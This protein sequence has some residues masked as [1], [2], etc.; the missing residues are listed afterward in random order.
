MRYGHSTTGRTII[1]TAELAHWML[2]AGR[3]LMGGFYVVAGVHHFFL[4]EPLAQLIS[5]RKIPAPRLILIVGSLFQSVAGLLLALSVA[6]M[7]AALGLIIF[8]LIASVMLLNFW[9]QAG[10]QRRSALTQWQC[11]LA[12]IGGLLALAVTQ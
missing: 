8:T 11:N 10:E 4:L 3:I 9:D 5:A 7:W 2:I 6:S 12:L 1:M